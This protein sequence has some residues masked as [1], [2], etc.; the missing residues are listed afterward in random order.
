MSCTLSFDS[1]ASDFSNFS[2]RYKIVAEGSGSVL[3]PDSVITVAIVGLLLCGTVGL[4][5]QLVHASRP[6]DM[7]VKSKSERGCEH[8]VQR[9][10][11]S[12]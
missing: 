7:A 1:F 10:Q 8:R 2:R 9:K 6:S 3:L 4:R 5:E 11:C 12:W